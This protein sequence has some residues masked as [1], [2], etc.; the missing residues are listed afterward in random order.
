MIPLPPSDLEAGALVIVIDDDLP[1]QTKE[2]HDSGE[3]E[4]V[5]HFYKTLQEFS[6]LCFSR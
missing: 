6:I 2:V 4:K 3:V 5:K 1:E